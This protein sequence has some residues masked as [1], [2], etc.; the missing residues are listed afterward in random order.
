MRESG[1]FY[2]NLSRTFPRINRRHREK[3]H[4]SGGQKALSRSLRFKQRD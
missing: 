3:E 2:Y 1:R 4:N